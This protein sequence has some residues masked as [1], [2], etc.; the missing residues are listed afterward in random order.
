MKLNDDQRH[1]KGFNWQWLIS[2]LK[3]LIPLLITTG[4][5]IYGWYRVDNLGAARDLKN[6]QREV[7]VQYLIE[8]YRCMA[9]DIA[10]RKSINKP[11]GGETQEEINNRL[12]NIERALTDIQLFGSNSQ[13]EALHKMCNDII[14]KMKTPGMSNISV[15]TRDLLAGLRDELRDYLGL[16]RVK[17]SEK[18]VFYL[19]V[20]Q[21]E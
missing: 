1:D 11:I 7:K 14:G 9:M 2:I 13:I 6:K 21:Q 4:V 18:E 19:R 10:G 15:E 16:E 5:G 3:L 8:A 17:D 12:K 20:F